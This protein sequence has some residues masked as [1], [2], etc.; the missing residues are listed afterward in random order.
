[1]E[2]LFVALR[3]HRIRNVLLGVGSATWP[4]RRIEGGGG[5]LFRPFT[6]RSWVVFGSLR[7]DRTT[8]PNSRDDEVTRL[9]GR[10]GLRG[11]GVG[12]RWWELEE[13][14]SMDDF[15][16]SELCGGGRV[17]V[18]TM[19]GLGYACMRVSHVRVC[20]CV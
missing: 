20:V 15:L 8:A 6:I 7:R 12:G 11:L 9:G 10:G 16:H 13:G 3:P 1:M 19:L 4:D 5:V 2:R 18:S 14:G 17:G